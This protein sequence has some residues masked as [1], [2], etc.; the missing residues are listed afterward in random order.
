M[1]EIEFS[2]PPYTVDDIYGTL[3]EAKDENVGYKIRGVQADKIWP[4]LGL[5]GE[6]VPVSAVNTA[7]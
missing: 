6:S 7:V 3:S 1:S 2:I 5:I 4:E